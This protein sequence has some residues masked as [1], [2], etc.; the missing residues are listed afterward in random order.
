MKKNISLFFILIAMIGCVYPNR[1][2]QTVDDR[3]GLVIV[4]A[5]PN[6]VLYID[7][8]EIGPAQKYNGKPEVLLVNPGTH[9]VQIRQ[10]SNILRSLDVFLGE[11]THREITLTGNNKQ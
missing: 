1:Q 6:A 10:G 4:G 2:V 7:G 9:S 8:L 11:G 3:P 5:P